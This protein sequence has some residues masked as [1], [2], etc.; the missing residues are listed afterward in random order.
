MSEK[1]TDKADRE[2]VR[3]C[4]QAIADKNGGV[5]TAEMVVE[6][7]KKKSSPLHDLFEWDI[8]KAAEAHWVETARRVIRSVKVVITTDTRQVST[9]Y[10][11]RDPDMDSGEQGYVS[12]PTLATDKERAK[13]AMASEFRRAIA[14]MERAQSI[15]EALDM[16]KE[17][18]LAKQYLESMADKL[19]A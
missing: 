12:L 16:H 1:I 18:E 14:A 19:A 13:A 15:A 7:A 5:L 17:V 4:L 8:K 11:V 9:V 3:E 2:A 10:Y 6:E